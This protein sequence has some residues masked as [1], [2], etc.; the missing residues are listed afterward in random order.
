MINS[1]FLSIGF[2]CAMAL[3]VSAEAKLYKWV[4][5]N[6]VTH[7]GEV[8]PPEYA[9]KDRDTLNKAGLLNKR[10]EKIDP[11]AEHAKEE[12][13]QKRNI[14]KQAEIEQKRRDSTLLNTYSNEKE[15]DMA[16][17]R[18]LVLINARIDSNK[19]LI[20]ST[21][22]TLDELNKEA[23]SRN[24]TGK[25][26]PVSLTRDISQ[27]QSRFDRYTT[28]LAKSE[29]EL[30]DVRARFDNDKMLYRKLKGDATHK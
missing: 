15:I 18:S 26:I 7:Y 19:M 12:A 23:E 2:I 25:K 1:K 6:G 10:P 9:N 11:A 30:D 8:I 21:Q 4:D 24:K 27:A 29:K 3:S 22:T 14:E 13:E 28:E 20:K 5:N 17:E 16:R